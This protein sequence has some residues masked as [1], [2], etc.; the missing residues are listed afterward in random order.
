[1]TNR[2]DRPRR[3]LGLRARLMATLAA[4]ALVL[5]MLMGALAYFTT[6]HYLLTERQN[7]ALR[8]AYANAALLRSDLAA[9]TPTVGQT[10]TGLGSGPGST[11]VLERRGV[12]Y[13]STLGIGRATLPVSLVQTIASDK[14]AIQTTTEGGTPRFFVGVP[15]TSVDVLVLPG[16]RPLRH[17][18]HPSDPA[19]R[20]RRRCC[21][22]RTARCRRRC[23]SQP[24]NPQA[25]H[26]GL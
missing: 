13:S 26:R 15:L 9:G 16:H 25:P 22:D 1:M 14:V 2:G 6:R 11:S 3:R 7:T 19:G 23:R 12:W 5:S 10:V 18:A 21:R 17:P 24:P 20:P 8:Q 4:A